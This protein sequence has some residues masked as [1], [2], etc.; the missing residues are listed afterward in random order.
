MTRVFFLSIFSRNFDDVTDELNFSQVCYLCICCV[1][2]WEDWSFTIT[3]SA[4]FNQHALIELMGQRHPLPILIIEK[5]FTLEEL[6]TRKRK[7]RSDV[8]TY[9]KR[10]RYFLFYTL[11][12]FQYQTHP[13]P[14]LEVWCQFEWKKKT[15]R[16]SFIFSDSLHVYFSLRLILFMKS[17]HTIL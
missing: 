10:S 1:T 14:T 7:F 11:I 9:I 3:I 13:Q 6:Y 16:K 8:V 4:H 2:K 15:I 5:G 12:A 17:K